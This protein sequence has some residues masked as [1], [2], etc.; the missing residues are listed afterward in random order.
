[1]FDTSLA[2]I[3]CSLSSHATLVLRDEHDFTKAIAKSN[4]IDIPPA[5]LAKLNPEAFPLLKTV[6]LGGE[7]CPNVLV[8]KWEKFVT[9]VNAYGPSEVTVTSSSGIVT[10]GKPIT[11]GK[12]M[13]N[14][15]Q[16]I[17]DKNSALVP[18]GV[19]GELVIGGAGVSV[20]YINR[21]E[22]TAERF[23]DNHFLNDGSKMYRTGD[24]CK[25]TDD[26][27]IMYLGRMDD[28]VKLKG[29]RIELDEVSAAVSRHK[30]V[31]SAA[32]IVKDELLVAYY[33]PSSIDADKVRNTVIEIL[34]HYMVPAV[35]VPID[36]M[37][38]NN[39]GKV[40]FVDV[41]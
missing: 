21:P 11:I 8:K 9:L 40:F 14:T 7:V 36:E 28:M 10:S 2:L 24:L 23:I 13:A 32:V 41:G 30:G 38:V 3:F 16:Y 26:G 27:E 18:I 34:P 12:P 29:Y 37:P 4:V 25:W 35:F 5:A 15:Y 22:L 17:L 39:N 31:E 19:P 6:V 33:S 20:G 1:M